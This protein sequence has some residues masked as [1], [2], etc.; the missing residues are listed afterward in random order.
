MNGT[1]KR[2]GDRQLAV[3]GYDPL[4]NTPFEF[5]GCYW[6]GCPICFDV[7]EPHPTRGKT[8]GYWYEKTQEKLAYLEDIGYQTVVMWECGWRQER[9]ENLHEIE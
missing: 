9:E 4:T 6:H 3:D 7:D 8:Y 2:L 1:E 5:M